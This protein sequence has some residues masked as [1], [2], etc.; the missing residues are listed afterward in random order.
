MVAVLAGA[1]AVLSAIGMP[2]AHAQKFVPAPNGA[3]NQQWVMVD[4]QIVP[5]SAVIGLDKKSNSNAL[6]FSPNAVK[7][8][9]GRV[10]YAYDASMLPAKRAIFESGC[11]E[12]EKFANL[13]F[14]VR[15]TETNYIN[16]ISTVDVSNSFVG[17]TGG[18]QTLNLADWANKYT[19]MHEL[20]HALGV[21]HE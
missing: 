6:S 20:A 18:A 10:P 2:K 8:P 7:W 11:R 4:D 17:M 21:I 5:A 16:V 19:A 12:W 1:C 9:G 13:K 15:T 3:Q 14:F